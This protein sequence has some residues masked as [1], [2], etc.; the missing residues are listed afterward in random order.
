M[1]QSAHVWAG[2]MAV[3][4][5]EKSSAKEDHVRGTRRGHHR[6]RCRRLWK[7]QQFQQQQRDR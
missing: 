2:A 4:H 3:T 6:D 1:P 5:K 7:Q